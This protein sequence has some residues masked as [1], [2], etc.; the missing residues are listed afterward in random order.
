MHLFILST[1]QGF[2]LAPPP[3]L[4]APWIDENSELG[5]AG[6]NHASGVLIA[7]LRRKWLLQCAK[8][9]SHLRHH[10]GRLLQGKHTELLF[11]Q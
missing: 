1:I 9:C 5:M 6:D 7:F 11:T 8:Q 3:T 10:T 2:W 4:P